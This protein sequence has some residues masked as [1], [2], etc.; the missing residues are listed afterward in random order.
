MFVS[1]LVN[2]VRV[3]C[4]VLAEEGVDFYVRDLMTGSHFLVAKSLC[5]EA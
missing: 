1:A 3:P 4:E 5:V 2:G